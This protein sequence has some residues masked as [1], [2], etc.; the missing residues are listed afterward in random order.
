MLI[1]HSFSLRFLERCLDTRV[2][3]ANLEDAG[4]FD[5]PIHCMKGVRIQIFVG[6][7]FPGFNYG[8]I[9]CRKNPYLNTYSHS[10]CFFN[11]KACVFSKIIRIF[12]DETWFVLHDAV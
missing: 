10:N 8:K 1:G 11:F 9:T 3:L 7:Y 6:P 4:H 12:L 5:E 2:T